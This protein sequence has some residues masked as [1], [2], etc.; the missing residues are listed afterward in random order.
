[1]FRLADVR[2]LERPAFVFAESGLE[3]SYAELAALVEQAK[4][5][6]FPR[7]DDRYRPLV[8][9]TDLDSLVEVLAHFELGLAVVLL[10]A[11]SPG[12]ERDRLLQEISGK[13]PFPGDRVVLATSGSTGRP[14]LVVHTE[15]SLIAA[16]RASQENLGWLPEGDRWHLA[17]PLCHVGGL[18]L[19]V[20]CLLARQTIVVGHARSSDPD[21]IVAELVRYRVT[22]ASFVPTQLRR[23]L[24]SLPAGGLPYLRVALVGGAPCPPELRLH[25]A[26]RSLHMLTTY[27]LTE[28]SSQVATERWSPLALG[29]K[30]HDRGGPLPPAAGFVGRPLAGV[31]VRLGAEG[32][33][34]VRGP[35]AMRQYLNHPSPFDEDGYL[36]TNDLGHI[37]EEGNL[38]VLGRIDNIVITGGENVSTEWVEAALLSLPGVREACALGVPDPDWGA[39]LVAV[40]VLEPGMFPETL[41]AGLE[42][43]LPKF[44]IPKE[45]RAVSSLPHLLSGKLDRQRIVALWEALSIP[46]RPRQ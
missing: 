36:V 31:T 11:R 21:S 22:L 34:A 42:S 27:G 43:Q 44:A 8:P 32:R 38:F 37:D 12:P 23:V 45:I 4:P 41:R 7:G 6:A 20:R 10:D 2:S 17:L 3:V 29:S 30:A 19:L 39:R 5:Y 14:K 18:A 9:L 1:M 33:I 25:A 26:E 46:L 24:G 16:A 28:M 13:K 15:A 35:M 40:V